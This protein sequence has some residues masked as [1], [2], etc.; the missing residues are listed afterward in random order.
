MALRYTNKD[1]KSGFTI[2][3]DLYVPCDSQTKEPLNLDED[4]KN[5]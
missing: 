5:V 4:R 3:C 1:L 2:D